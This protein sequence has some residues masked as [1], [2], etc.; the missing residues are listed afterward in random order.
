MAKVPIYIS[1]SDIDEMCAKGGKSVGDFSLMELFEFLH[2]IGFE[3]SQIEY[4]E[5]LHYTKHG[6]VP[7]FGGRLISWERQDK[8]WMQHPWC[9]F[10]NI[11]SSQTDE[12]HKIDLRVMSKMYTTEDM[13]NKLKE[14]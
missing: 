6:K 3:D 4:E 7:V 12:D 1:V 14:D 11:M 13:I 9:T 10:E 8:E 2:Q 5:C